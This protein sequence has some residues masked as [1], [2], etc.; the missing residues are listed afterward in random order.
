MS[1]G[2]FPYP[3]VV[4]GSASFGNEPSV[5]SASWRW[6]YAGVEISN[7]PISHLGQVSN[8]SACTLRLRLPSGL[9]RGF[10]ADENEPVVG[11]VWPYATISGG[12]GM[13]DWRPN[14]D[15]CYTIL[16]VVLH[17]NT[18]N[19][20]GELEGIGATTGFGQ[21][22]ENTITVGPDQWLVLQ[23]IFRTTRTDYFAVKLS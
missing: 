2:V 17:D 20:Y 6:S 10:L 14:L 8:D 13:L 12:N 4:G 11:R 18:P 21:S 19:C 23:N 15:G 3:L 1:P 5:G 16:P 7:F 9:W 22:S